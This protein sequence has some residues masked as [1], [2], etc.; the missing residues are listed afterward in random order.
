MN[1]ANMARQQ[2]FGGVRKVKKTQRPPNCNC[3][4]NAYQVVYA[5]TPI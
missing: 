5:N 2:E 4:R 1:V 3:G